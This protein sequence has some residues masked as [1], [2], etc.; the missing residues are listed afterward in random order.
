MLFLNLKLIANRCILC[1]VV[2]KINMNVFFSGNA[3]KVGIIA[4]QLSTY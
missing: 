2:K 1:K 4:T 3:I